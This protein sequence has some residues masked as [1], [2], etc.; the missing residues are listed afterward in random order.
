VVVLGTAQGFL[1]VFFP[2][3]PPPQDILDKVRD[4]MS[5]LSVFKIKAYDKKVFIF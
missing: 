3:P 4:S 2:P 5:H 1:G